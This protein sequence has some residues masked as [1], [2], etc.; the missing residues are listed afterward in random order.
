MACSYRMVVVWYINEEKEMKKPHR[1]IYKN[2]FEYRANNKGFKVVENEDG[3]FQIQFRKF[4]GK[5][6]VSSNAYNRLGVAFTEFG[7]SDETFFE[8]CHGFM[9]YIQSK[10][11]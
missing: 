8:P 9:L 4:V 7:I 3:N 10:E 2:G 11:Q 6:I 1:K 5:G